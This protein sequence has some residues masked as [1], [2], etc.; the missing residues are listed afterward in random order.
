MKKNSEILGLPVISITEGSELGRVKCLVINAA[1]GA[2][3]AMVIEDDNWYKVG[4][5]LLPFAAVIGVGDNAITVENSSS[6]VPIAHDQEIEKLLDANVKVIGAKVLTQRGGFQG[7]VSEYSVDETGKIGSC[8]IEGPNGEVDQIQGQCIRTFGKEIL[9]ISDDKSSV[10]PDSIVQGETVT[11]NPGPTPTT[12]NTTNPVVEEMPQ[13][14]AVE[15]SDDSVKKF[16]EKQRAY[17][18]GKKATR[19]IEADNGVVIV[20]QGGEITKEVIQEAQNAGK[21]VELSMNI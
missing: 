6:I 18:L 19:R 12:N 11:I 1:K 13:P 20:E 21:L 10:T 4:A 2:V 16:E 17:L 9:I 8:Q 7:R 15:S 5:K 14:V 3:A